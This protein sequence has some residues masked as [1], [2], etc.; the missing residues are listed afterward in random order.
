MPRGSPLH[1]L[2]RAEPKWSYPDNLRIRKDPELRLQS[3]SASRLE[4]YERGERLVWLKF[5]AKGE[6][7]AF[8][9]RDDDEGSLSGP[10]SII[11]SGFRHPAWVSSRDGEWRA[12][13][14]ALHVN[15]PIHDSTFTR[16]ER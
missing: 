14:Q 13:I 3:P 9:F 2:S 11:Q 8:G 15:V 12:A 10:W 5:D 4:V 7:Y 1:A 6:P 16:H